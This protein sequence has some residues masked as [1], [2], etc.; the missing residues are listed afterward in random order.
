MKKDVIIC[1]KDDEKLVVA[2]VDENMVAD[3]G[4]NKFL[5]L[6]DM[7]GNAYAI[8]RESIKYIKIESCEEEA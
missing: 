1:F 8:D 2:G 3:A 7:H 4:D 6:I 5:A